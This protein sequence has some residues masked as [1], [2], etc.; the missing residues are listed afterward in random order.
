MPRPLVVFALSLFTLAS[1][2]VAPCTAIQAASPNEGRPNVIVFIT[3]DESWL[4]RSVYGWS[5]LPTPN[6]ERVAQSGVL[7]T[8][9]YSSA[10]SC[11]A[12]RAALLTG[13]NFW[14]LEQ[15][16]FIQ[17]WLPKKFPVFPDLLAAEGYHVGRAGKGWGPG[18]YP[19]DAHGPDSAGKP[20]QS[21]RIPKPQRRDGINPID[22]AAN[23]AVFLDER[24][25]DA[26]FFFWAG[27]TEPHGPWANDNY[28]KLA[29]EHGLSQSDLSVPGF[30][31]DTPGI[32]K[33]LGNIRYEITYADQ[34]L[35][36]FLAILEQ[37]GELENTLLIVTAD[38]G[39][40]IPRSKASP[41]DWG[42][43]V[44]LVIMWPG[45]AP[46]GRTVT[47]FANFPDLAPTILQA[48][49][50]A[51]PQSMSGRSLLP[52]LLSD[53]S[54]QVDPA[55][56][57]VVTGLEWHGELPPVNRASRTIRDATHA[58]IVNYGH[59]PGLEIDPA[60][61]LPDEEFPETA[62]TAGLERLLLRHPNHRQ[63]APW[64]DLYMTDAPPEEL[65]D[66]QEDPWQLHNLADDENYADIKQQLKVKLHTYQTKT[67]DPRAT[68]KLE[69][70]EQTR[71]FVEERKRSGYRK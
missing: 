29:D 27:I 8:H 51:V 63:L 54:G 39:T 38:N 69:T 2:V 32:R 34:Q 58:Y 50:T 40:A 28:Q 13:R 71:Q 52:I 11:A 30:L 67:L 56:D 23:F 45:H 15:G 24:P 42:V 61:M 41:Y 35:G 62:E 19:N 57:F 9:G 49:G 17:A 10:P 70:F 4:E 5:K 31:P 47:D 33:L 55:R 46:A 3:D 6:F 66:L 1:C 25:A 53:K 68:G 43:H 20:Y 12:A 26:P 22:Y 59:V 60:T 16:A 36:R 14:E 37:R 65:Y 21:A 18:V 7:F 64:R 48:T 44:P